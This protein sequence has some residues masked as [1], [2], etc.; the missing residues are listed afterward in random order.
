MPVATEMPASP[1]LQK[2]R[3]GKWYACRLLTIPTRRDIW[4]C[5]CVCVSVCLSIRLLHI[6][7][8]HATAELIENSSCNTVWGDRLSYTYV[9]VLSSVQM[10]ATWRVLLNDNDLYCRLGL[11][12]RPINFSRLDINLSKQYALIWQGQRLMGRD[13]SSTS[14]LGG[15]W[16]PWVSKGGQVTKNIL[17]VICTNVPFL[18]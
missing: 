5:V 9:H 1:T 6:W 4:V 15:Q 13:G 17:S 3:S 11:C 18:T 14:T 16:E 12:C 2:L 10:G 8:S 7:V